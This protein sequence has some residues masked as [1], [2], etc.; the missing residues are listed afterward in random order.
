MSSRPRLPLVLWALATWVLLGLSAL[1]CYGGVRHLTNC[2]AVASVNRQGGHSLDCQIEKP[3]SSEEGDAPSSRAA[4]ALLALLAL[5]HVATCARAIVCAGV[6][7]K[8]TAALLLLASPLTCP[9]GF[10]FI[11]AFQYLTS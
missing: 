7:Q 2:L 10:L 3:T 5:L 4:L 9:G 11:A 1:Y 6:Y 8:L